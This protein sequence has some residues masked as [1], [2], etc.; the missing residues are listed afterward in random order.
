MR[1]CFSFASNAE[2]RFGGGGANSKWRLRDDSDLRMT[3]LWACAY[4]I[5]NLFFLRRNGES[6]ALVDLPR[7]ENE[8]VSLHPPLP[9]LHSSVIL[10]SAPT[11]I[12]CFV[13]FFK[14]T[15]SG[16]SVDT[17]RRRISCDDVL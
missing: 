1:Y 6:D 2:R 4:L 12:F 10:H 16:H 14:C 9:L 11:L 7:P 17:R 8:E 13:L 15:R 3:A 5:G